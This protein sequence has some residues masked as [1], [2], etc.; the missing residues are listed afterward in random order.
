MV[1][2]LPGRDHA[3]ALPER[4]AMLQQMAVLGGLSADSLEILLAASHR[5]SCAEGAEFFHEGEPG[6]TMY[7]LES[8]AVEVL[9]NSPRGQ[10]RLGRLVAG[11]CF[12]EMALMDMSPR[13][14]TIRAL[15][16]C[17]AIELPFA[18]LLTLSERDIAQ[19][20]LLMMNMGREVSRR[21]RIADQGA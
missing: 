4:I 2:P 20:A 9:K 11:D 12:G 6:D 14:A 8:G 13:S 7:I 1:Q 16:P 18:A 17:E 10:R 19:F 21:L 5:V 15:Q 3:E